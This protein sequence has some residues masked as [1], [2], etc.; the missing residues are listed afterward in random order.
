[1]KTLLFIVMLFPI[2][3]FGQV[4]GKKAPWSSL[5]RER[6]LGGTGKPGKSF[7]VGVG[8]TVTDICITG[9]GSYM[10]FGHTGW[11]GRLMNGN[12]FYGTYGSGSYA[13]WNCAGARTHDKWSVG[14]MLGSLWITDDWWP[15]VNFG[16]GR[17]WLT[18]YPGYEQTNDPVF[19]KNVFEFGSSGQIGWFCPWVIVSV[20]RQLEMTFGA[21]VAF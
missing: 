11:F 19:A 3:L 8:T 15:T 4:Q 10:F 5:D 17:H 21:S 18:T 14:F 20:N 2:V 7:S 1:M 16:Y 13:E 6:M 12:G 9:R